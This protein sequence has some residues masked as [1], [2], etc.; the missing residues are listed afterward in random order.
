MTDEYHD[1]FIS[2]AVQAVH[3]ATQSAN[4]N[5]DNALEVAVQSMKNIKAFYEESYADP[6]TFVNW[7]TVAQRLANEANDALTKIAIIL[8][9]RQKDK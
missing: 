9:V 2:D 3:K 1:P 5:L 4:K 8:K 6:H 7:H